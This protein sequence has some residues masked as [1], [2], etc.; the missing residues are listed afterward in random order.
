M[1][2]CTPGSSSSCFIPIE[3]HRRNKT[4]STFTLDILKRTHN[5]IGFTI[6]KIKSPIVKRMVK[7]ALEG[8]GPV[9][10]AQTFNR[11]PIPTLSRRGRYW[12]FSTIQYLLTSKTLIGEFQPTHMVK[13]KATPIGEPIQAYPPV[14]TEQ[15]FYAV[16]NVLATRKK[17]T[18]GRTGKG[19]AN[20]FGRI[21]KSGD[22]GGFFQKC[23]GVV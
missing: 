10:I 11:E 2:T 7:M 8:L 4:S 15:E 23:V 1:D 22:D 3:V 20:L 6:N 5:R 14:I 18:K 9:S 12:E 17:K 16:Q 13:G 21:L 19:V